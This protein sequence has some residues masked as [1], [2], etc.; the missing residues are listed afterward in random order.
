MA[1]IYMYNHLKKDLPISR[2][3]QG[4]DATAVGL[5]PNDC[6]ISA[7]LHGHRV[8]A[9]QQLYG[10]PTSLQSPYYFFLDILSREHCTEGAR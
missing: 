1:S 10:G 8:A 2:L 9:L 4:N 5:L 3:L 6:T 7:R